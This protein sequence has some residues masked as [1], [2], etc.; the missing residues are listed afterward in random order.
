MSVA[1]DMAACLFGLSPG[2][3]RAGDA[4][5]H[6]CRDLPALARLRLL[7]TRRDSENVTSHLYVTRGSR[8]RR[9]AGWAENFEKV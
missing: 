4:R 8:G 3:P 5:A 6:E 9:E 7:P 2:L 1:I